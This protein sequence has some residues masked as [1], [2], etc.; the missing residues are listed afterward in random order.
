MSLLDH[1][2]YRVR[3]VAAWWFARR[4][5]LKA[6]ITLQSLARLTGGDARAAEYAADVL[7]TF[8][9]PSVIPALE[10]ALRSSHP[11]A[12]RVAVVRALGTIA[13][14]AGKAAVVAALADPDAATRAA[15]A[16]AYFELRGPRDGEP[17]VALVADGDARVRREA[18]AVAG[19]LRTAAARAALEDR[20]AN[21]PDALVR[22]NAAWA[23]RELGDPASRPA[24]ERAASS[25][26][27]AFV[28][29]V[30]K[31]AIAVRR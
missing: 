2:D 27:V 5:A 23:L 26:P 19:N 16:T 8:R 4:P 29:S 6:A 22:R 20:L 10:Q 28:R 18:V 25:D 1:D 12:T 17:L 24:L 7:G 13:D 11:A 3:E 14:P 15:A 31:S 30:A 21:D 9:H